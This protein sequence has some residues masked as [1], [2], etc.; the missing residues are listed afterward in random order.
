MFRIGAEIDFIVRIDL[1]KRKK[2]KRIQQK[3]YIL[4]NTIGITI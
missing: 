1:I 4:R 2:T 3:N